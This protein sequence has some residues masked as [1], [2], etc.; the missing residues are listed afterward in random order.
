[1]FLITPI[2]RIPRYICMLKVTCSSLFL[3][4]IKPNCFHLY[5]EKELLKY[6][7]PEHEDYPVITAAIKIIELAA[8]SNEKSHERKINISTLVALERRF[9]SVHTPFTTQ[10]N[11][12]Q[13]NATHRNI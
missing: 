9:Y 5:S 8:Q 6:T 12:T 10:H 3:S 2:Q 7:E 13:R 1:M 11:T 4:F